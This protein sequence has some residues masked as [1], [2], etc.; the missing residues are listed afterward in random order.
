MELVFIRHGQGEHTLDLPHSLQIENPSLTAEGAEQA[1]L[2]RYQKPLTNKDIIMISPIRR[3]LQTASIW[4]ENINCRKIVNPLVSPR[5]FPIHKESDTLPCDKI[6]DLEV[7]KN[8]FPTYEIEMNLPLN[9]WTEGINVLSE[10][11]FLILAKEFISYCKQFQK[12][13]I[14]LVSHDGTITSYRQMLSGKKLT[15]EDFPKETGCFE[16]SC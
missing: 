2:L 10:S 7:I 1:R 8:D 11:E 4:S 9:L 13:K 14:Y 3:T 6:M 5:V 16:I 12:E 15:R